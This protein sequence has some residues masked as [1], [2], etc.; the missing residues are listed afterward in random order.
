MPVRKRKL[1]HPLA[2]REKINRKKSPIGMK[3]RRPLTPDQGARPKRPRPAS[4][5]S[6]SRRKPRTRPA[7][8]PYGLIKAGQPK[9][10]PK[11]MKRMPRVDIPDFGGR[12]PKRKSPRKMTGTLKRLSPLQVRERRT[13]SQR[14]LKKSLAGARVTPR[15]LKPL[16]KIRRR[17]IK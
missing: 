8:N 9:R 17:K 2:A 16:S 6:Q 14:K 11:K 15:T 13:R 3:R 1:P 7:R 10:M 12:L 4:P 5:V